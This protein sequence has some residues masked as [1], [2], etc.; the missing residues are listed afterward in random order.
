MN[1]EL[2]LEKT[3]KIR[4]EPGIFEWTKWE[5]GRTGPN[6]MTQAELREAGFS[7][8]LDYR[9]RLASRLLPFAGSGNV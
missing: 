2:K 5:A 8:D 3:L 9:L 6:F 1:P 4:I 7:V